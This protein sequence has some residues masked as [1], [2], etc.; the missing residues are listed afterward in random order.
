MSSFAHARIIKEMIVAIAPP[1]MNGLLFPHRILQLSL[2]SPTYGCTSTPES[3]PAIHTSASM[4]LLMPK[5][6]KYGCH[7]MLDMVLPNR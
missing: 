7:V 2:F 5:E 6:S 3:G 4:A 1:T